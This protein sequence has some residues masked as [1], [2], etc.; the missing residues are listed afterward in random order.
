[1]TARRWWAAVAVWCGIIFALSALPDR[2]QGG[3]PLPA[4]M[5]RK[6]AHLI[7]YGFLAFLTGQA[8]RAGNRPRRIVL[9]GALLFCVLYAASDEFHQSFVPGRYAKVR[10]VALDALGAAL[11]LSIYDRRALAPST[12]KETPPP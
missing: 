2:T 4:T 8:L 6:M 10:D 7:E 5:S 12:G 1:M 11:V 3:A 9:G